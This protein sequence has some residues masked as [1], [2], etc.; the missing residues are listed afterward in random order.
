MLSGNG[1]FLLSDFNSVLFSKPSKDIHL[2]TFSEIAAVGLKSQA[3]TMCLSIKWTG[4]RASPSWQ[5][6]VLVQ[7]HCCFTV[8]GSLIHVMKSWQNQVFTVHFQ[9]SLLP[10]IMLC[11]QWIIDCLEV[12]IFRMY[13]VFKTK[14]TVLMM[15]PLYGKNS[16]LSGG[17][18][19]TLVWNIIYNEAICSF[20]FFLITVFLSLIYQTK[21]W[22]HWKQ[23]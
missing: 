2:G 11:S 10:P 9:R 20:F 18:K 5:C 22:N 21:S 17:K 3:A 16:F 4:L 6:A 14:I 8:A 7:V 19:G 13:S 23:R 1:L 15:C 12:N